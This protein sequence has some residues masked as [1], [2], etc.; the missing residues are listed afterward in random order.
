VAGSGH[1]EVE[2]VRT[3]IDGGVYVAAGPLLHAHREQLYE[4]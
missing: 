3:E 2:R 1:D 4:P